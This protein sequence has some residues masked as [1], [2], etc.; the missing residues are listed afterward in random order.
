MCEV[1]EGMPKLN[2]TFEPHTLTNLNI[3]IFVEKVEYA[4]NELD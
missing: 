4:F 1:K 3:N 2:F